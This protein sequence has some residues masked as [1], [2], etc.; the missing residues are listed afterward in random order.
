[1]RSAYTVF[2]PFQFAHTH[3]YLTKKLLVSCVANVVAA[4]LATEDFGGSAHGYSLRAR[5]LRFRCVK[6][7]NKGDG[8][9]VVM[10]V[11]GF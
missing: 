6:S 1:M 4:M 8:G 11:G 9:G 10:R 5:R 3:T 2:R 7:E